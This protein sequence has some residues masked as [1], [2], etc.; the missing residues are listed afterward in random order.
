MAVRTLAVPEGKTV[1]VAYTRGPGHARELARRAAREGWR[2]VVAVGGDGT[3]SEVAAGLVG[4][5][6]TLG[7]VPTGTGCD[8]ARSAGI[9]TNPRAALQALWTYHP[10]PLDLGHLGSHTF[11][12]AAGFGFDAQVAREVNRLK[13][14]AAQRGSLGG[15]GTWPYL[16]GVGHVLRSYRSPRV[17][18]KVDD[19]AT[20]ELTILLAAFANGTSYAGGM[21]MAPQAALGDGRLD[22]VLVESLRPAQVVA[23]LPTAFLG[24]HVRHPA[25]RVQRFASLTLVPQEDIWL[26]CDGEDVGF[27]PAGQ[28]LVVRVEEAALRY[29]GPKPPL[30]HSP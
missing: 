5:A 21:R 10:L 16:L 12:N 17:R 25:V 22:L 29:L 27:L 15:G 23:L 18:L 4:T 6:A 26:H 24:W 30:G 20:V 19:Q 7:V 11:V 1:H 3:V 9:P 8:F 14:A 28:T 13:A 2:T